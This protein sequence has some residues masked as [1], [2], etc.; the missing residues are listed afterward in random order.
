MADPLDDRLVLAVSPSHIA[1]SFRT[2]AWI[3]DIFISF[4]VNT[5]DVGIPYNVD[6]SCN[7]DSSC[8]EYTSLINIFSSN[9]LVLLHF[10][11]PSVNTSSFFN[12]GLRSLNR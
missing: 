6:N 10:E 3:S 7:V 9:I 4:V 8:N 11:H 5:C 12:F 2:N 1:C